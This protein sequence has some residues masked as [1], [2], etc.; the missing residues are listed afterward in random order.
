ML[1]NDK[2]S[3]RAPEIELYGV[4]WHLVKKWLSKTPIVIRTLKLRNLIIVVYVATEFLP[5][6]KIPNYVRGVA[7]PVC[8][9]EDFAI[10]IGKGT[11]YRVY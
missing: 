6:V 1:C 3:A 8:L 11:R 7:S 5:F 4:F 10:C 2:S 9:V